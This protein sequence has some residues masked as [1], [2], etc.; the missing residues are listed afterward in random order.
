M[1]LSDLFARIRG[2]K[3]EFQMDFHALVR[4]VAADKAPEPDVIARALQDAGKTVEDLQKAVELL[5]RR[6][7][8][9]QAIAQAESLEAERPGIQQQI[10]AANRE[11]EQANERHD[12]IVGPL[13]GK[14]YRI[15]QA[16][17]DADEARRQLRDTCTNLELLDAMADVNS[18]RDAL[19]KRRHELDR[20][21]DELKRRGQAALEESAYARSEAEA[22]ALHNQGQNQ[23]ARAK[24]YEPELTRLAKKLATL[25]QREQEISQ[26]MLEP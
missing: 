15:I 25:E 11:L 14:L 10:A 18:E 2:K 16:G 6:H 1:N 7:Q 5:Q 9:R 21:R 13:D 24:Q 23:L 4:L 8:W 20:E 17:R 19:V 22:Q 12:E 3:R 26:K